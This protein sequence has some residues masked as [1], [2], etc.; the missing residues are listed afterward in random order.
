M[1]N[2]HTG[3][4]IGLNANLTA[5]SSSFVALRGGS[6]IKAY[7]PASLRFSEGIIV[8]CESNGVWIQLDKAVAKSEQSRSIVIR[9]SRITQIIGTAL[10]IQGSGESDYLPYNV[11]IADNRIQNVGTESRIYYI[12][13]PP[14]DKNKEV[15]QK[16]IR[17]SYDLLKIRPEATIDI[18]HLRVLSLHV[19]SNAIIKASACGLRLLNVKSYDKKAQPPCQSK[20]E[21]LMQA[22]VGIPASS[23]I[24]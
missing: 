20:V 15:E 1:N 10:L 19:N 11:E 6:A 2:F 23:L 7:N 24:E 18:R 17:E 4:N 12:A 21:S 16:A 9:E 5:L 8:K 14:E 22:G 13:G 3:V